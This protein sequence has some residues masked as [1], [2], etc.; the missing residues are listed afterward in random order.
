MMLVCS[1]FQQ[2]SKGG[3]GPKNES[4]HSF[5]SKSGLQIKNQINRGIN[6]TDSLG[7]DYRIRYIPISITNDS[8]IS[9]HLQLE[10]SKE[11][12]HP[13]PESDEKFKLIPLPEEWALDGAI[14]TDS[15]LGNLPKYIQHPNINTTVRS[16][17]EI[18]IA[19]ASMYP[20]PAKTTGVLPRILFTQNEITNFTECGR[21]LRKDRLSNQQMPIALKVI[22]G[23]WCMVIPCGQYSY[24]KN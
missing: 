18:I 13:N 5:T 11:Y 19:I 10:F 21:L 20:R 23:E 9:I 15:M 2:T 8:T 6:Y 1:C 12:N 4:K 16:G 14:V 7:I 3:L 22:I 17:E 24:F